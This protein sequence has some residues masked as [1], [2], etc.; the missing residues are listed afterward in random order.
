M[1]PKSRLPP[2]STAPQAMPKPRRSSAVATSLDAHHSH[3]ASFSSSAAVASRMLMSAAAAASAV[4]EAALVE[5]PALP[6][7]PEPPLLLTGEP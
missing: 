4:A 7:P 2:P 6:L 3:I 5:A 1:A